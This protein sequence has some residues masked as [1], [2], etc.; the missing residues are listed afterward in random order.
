MRR[1][2]TPAP[3]RMILTDDKGRRWL[4]VYLQ[5]PCGKAGPLLRQPRSSPGASRRAERSRWRTFAPVAKGADGLP[6]S[7]SAERGHLSHVQ[8]VA[9]RRARRP[10]VSDG[11][12]QAHRRRHREASGWDT[13]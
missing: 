5:R 1:F 13:W 9:A 8:V 3:A 10:L 7:P 6:R 11:M 2:F 4:P 12:L